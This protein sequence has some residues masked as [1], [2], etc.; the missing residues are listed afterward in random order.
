MKEDAVPDS[1]WFQRA[2]NSGE[3]LVGKDTVRIENGDAIDYSMDGDVYHESYHIS[4]TG[5]ILS[6]KNL[7]EIENRDAINHAANISGG[8][9]KSYHRQQRYG[10]VQE[11]GYEKY[12]QYKKQNTRSSKRERASASLQFNSKRKE[13]PSI[14]QNRP[15]SE[16]PGYGFFMKENDCLDITFD[17][18]E[19]YACN[20][21]TGEIFPAG[22]RPPSPIV[23]YKLQQALDD[24]TL[25]LNTTNSDLGLSQSNDECCFFPG[26]AEIYDLEQNEEFKS[27][28]HSSRINRENSLLD[29]GSGGNSG[30]HNIS[31][32]SL[33][34]N[35]QD[36]LEQ[37]RQSKRSIEEKRLGQTIVIPRS[38]L[39]KSE[40]E[41]I[42][43]PKSCR[44]IR[45]LQVGSSV[46]N[47]QA[48]KY[49][50]RRKF[51][52]IATIFGISIGIGIMAM[53]LFWPA[54]IL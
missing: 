6:G 15:V 33:E 24:T 9:S 42:E 44:P 26:Q 38:S 11:K 43:E 16:T 23:L 22:A 19:S 25:T 13:D 20:E 2:K 3:L 47:I 39:Y 35:K 37:L 41:H 5:E 10:K 1:K 28:A 32:T 45:E 54:R 12:E 14:Q 27:D 18:I 4:H 50:C 48:E 40:E 30:E 17:S 51:A 21:R 31:T 8:D 36:H 49:Y 7:T 29:V 46:T 53:A 34:R 52:L